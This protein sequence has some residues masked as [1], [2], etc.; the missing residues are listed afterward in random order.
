[1]SKQV[2]NVWGKPIEI[3]VH[4]KSKSVWVATGDYMGK[5]IE[6]Q[7]RTEGAATKLWRETAQY[8]GN[9]GAPP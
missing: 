2:V 8:R 5:R 7:G 6:A 3:A 1:M 4:Q 9:L